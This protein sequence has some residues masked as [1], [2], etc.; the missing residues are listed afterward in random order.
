MAENFF[1]SQVVMEA[2]EDIV[3]MQAQVLVF[4]QFADFAPLSA[5]RENLVLLRRL[6]EKQKNMCFRCI[7]CDDPAAKELLEEVMSHF[8]KFGHEVDRSN[9]MAVFAEVEASLDDLEDGL[10]FAEKNGYFPGEEPGGETPP[11]RM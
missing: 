11:Y 6:Q 4:S 5:Q 1:A 10:D 8:E 9:P 3:D 7:L 2:I